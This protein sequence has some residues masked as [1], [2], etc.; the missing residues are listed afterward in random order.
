[1][2]TLVAQTI[3]N[4]T[5]STSSANVIQGSARAWV[6]FGYISSAIT[7][8]KSYNVSSVTRTAAGQYAV[9]FTNA[10]VDANY[11]TIT[12]SS[13]INN[14]VYGKFS[15]IVGV[16]GTTVT[17]TTSSVTV[18]SSYTSGTFDEDYISVAIFG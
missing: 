1:M 2:S 17:P 15:N 12:S 9:N 7:T 18:F 5:V 4:G 13:S 16:T 6:N 3:S 11:A 10:M 14:G 8:R